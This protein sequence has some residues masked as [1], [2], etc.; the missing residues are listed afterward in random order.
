MT[1]P[2]PHPVAA[3]PASDEEI[4]ARVLEGDAALYEILMRR[5]NQRMYRAVRSI[6]KSE[7]E[8]EDILQE[9]Y[10]AA[11]EHLRS[12]DGRA[13]VSTW[14][15]RIAVN[16]ALDRL[17]RSS[18]LVALDGWPE[19]DIPAPDPPGAVAPSPESQSVSHELTR[20]LARAIDALPAI[21]RSV[22]VMREVEGLSTDDT[23]AC[24]DLEPATVKT[25]LH[26]ARARLRADL[27]REVGASAR[28]TFCFG[29]TRCDELVAR[30]LGSLPA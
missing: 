27:V 25:R 20:L 17:R 29:S 12:F 4:V 5:H 21:Y 6:L 8:V 15:V 28:E 1:L 16:K 7:S 30:V 23:A 24:L 11:F 3:H 14:L 13:R 9:A 2:Q 18:R 26:R 10:L 22:Y 19:E